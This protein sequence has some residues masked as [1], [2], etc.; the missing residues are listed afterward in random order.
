MTDSE[1]PNNCINQVGPKSSS[2]TLKWNHSTGIVQHIK[3]FCDFDIL[4]FSYVLIHYIVDYTHNFLSIFICCSGP[5]ITFRCFEVGLGPKK[6]IFLSQYFN[7]IFDITDCVMQNDF[8]LQ[9]KLG[10]F[11]SGSSSNCRY[12][13]QIHNSEF[14]KCENI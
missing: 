5:M 10:C 8:F 12:T 13:S 1:T 2:K 11:S 6:S 9:A 14:V 3:F 7:K 4:K